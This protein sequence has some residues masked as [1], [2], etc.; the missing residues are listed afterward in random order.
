MF[1]FDSRIR[2]VIE[3]LEPSYNPIGWLRQQLV[4]L[5]PRIQL[6]LPVMEEEQHAS[7]SKENFSIALLLHIECG[8]RD[9]FWA[10]RCSMRNSKV[11]RANQN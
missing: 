4:T 10:N 8:M 2:R 7:S 6:L 3:G 11:R 1:F 9:R 5:C